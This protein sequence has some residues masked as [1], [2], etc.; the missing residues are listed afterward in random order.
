[1]ATACQTFRMGL[2]YT[3]VSPTEWARMTS[4]SQEKCAIARPENDYKSFWMMETL[5]GAI[6]ET[7][8]IV[9]DSP[10]YDFLAH[11]IRIE[12]SDQSME[13]FKRAEIRDSCRVVW[14]VLG[15][16]WD[17]CSDGIKFIDFECEVGRERQAERRR[18]WFLSDKR[19]DLAWW[20]ELVRDYKWSFEPVPCHDHCEVCLETLCVLGDH[21]GHSHA[22]RAT[23]TEYHDRRMCGRCYLALVEISKE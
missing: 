20:L 21:G 13:F 11:I 15:K 7:E 4:E 2:F 23:G 1:M 8:D 10:E 9:A 14:T 18:Q 19:G 6:A 12:V 3:A 22:F 5:T 16:T 17:K